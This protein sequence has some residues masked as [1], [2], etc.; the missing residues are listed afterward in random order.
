MGVNGHLRSGGLNFR[1][2]AGKAKAR[3]C[4]NGCGCYREQ[5]NRLETTH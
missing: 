4:F 3:Q 1:S 5:R 2:T